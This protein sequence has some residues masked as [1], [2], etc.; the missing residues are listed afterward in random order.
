MLGSGKLSD[1]EIAFY[2]GVD[3]E[4]VRELKANMQP[5]ETQQE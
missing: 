1:E 3:I 4:K 5:N 2:S